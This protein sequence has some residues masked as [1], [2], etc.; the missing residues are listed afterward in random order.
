MGQ[1]TPGSAPAPNVADWEHVNSLKRRL[2]NA[3]DNTPL[4]TQSYQ[5]D[6]ADHLVDEDSHFRQYLSDPLEAQT[7][8]GSFT[9]QLQAVESNQNNNLFLA[10]KIQVVDSSGASVATLLNITRDDV[11]VSQGAVANRSFTGSLGA[12]YACAATDRLLIELG[13]GGTPASAAGVNGHNGG[14][15]WGCDASSGD[16]PVDDTE[17]AT[18]YRGWIAFTHDFIMTPLQSLRSMHQFRAR[19]N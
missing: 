9:M 13:L 7:I 1:T 19:R 3:P 4:T 11:E 17:T 18:T 2:L 15:R 6:A 14:I 16:L 12:S 5:P 10:M 8:S